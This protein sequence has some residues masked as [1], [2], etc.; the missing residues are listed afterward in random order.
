MSNTAKNTFKIVNFDPELQGLCQE[1]FLKDGGDGDFTKYME[2]VIRKGLAA[3]DNNIVASPVILT[4]VG[5]EHM[6]TR[7]QEDPKESDEVKEE[8]LTAVSSTETP[9]EL[10]NHTIPEIKSEDKDEWE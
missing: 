8:Q 4:D 2:K 7:F 6:E 1:G 9:T 3:P 5:A 10:I